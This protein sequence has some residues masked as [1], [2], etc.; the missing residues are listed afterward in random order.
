[1]GWSST[2]DQEQVG[3]HTDHDFERGR[4]RL[5]ELLPWARAEARKTRPNTTEESALAG[6]TFP[7]ATEDNLDALMIYPAPLGGW[8][9][10]VV[11][12]EVPPGIPNAMGTP[13]GTPLRTRQEAEE[14]GKAIL[15]GICSMPKR[16]IKPGSVFLLFKIA[17]H[18]PPLPH[19]LLEFGRRLSADTEAREEAIARIEQLLTE[20]RLD[21]SCDVARFNRLDQ[22]EKAFLMA[23]LTRATMAGVYAYPPRRDKSPSGHG[24]HATR[25]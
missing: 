10:D 24:Q 22:F 8:H 20:Y 15:V 25:Q 23:A 3:N 4:K 19:E 6:V 9:A 7:Y 16:E 13:V 14:H 21:D 1:M 2:G 12:K 17:V 18:L 11:L 5:R